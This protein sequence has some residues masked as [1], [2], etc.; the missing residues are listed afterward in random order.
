M[1][2]GTSIKTTTD[3]TQV[4]TF[5]DAPPVVEVDQAQTRSRINV[6]DLPDVKSQLPVTPASRT[7]T[8]GESPMVRGRVDM[9]D[10]PQRPKGKRQKFLKV[11]DA[12]GVTKVGKGLFRLAGSVLDRGVETLLKRR[13][14]GADFK[15]ED[16]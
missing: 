5:D 3:G 14:V 8:S 2:P 16:A 11:P 13:D 1:K 10:E 15:P 7:D 9:E 12:K 4:V 6:E